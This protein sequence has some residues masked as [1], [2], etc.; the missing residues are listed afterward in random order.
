[1]EAPT[2]HRSLKQKLKSRPFHCLPPPTTIPSALVRPL[3]DYIKDKCMRHLA[4]CVGYRAARSV[5][6]SAGFRYDALSYKLNFDESIP[7]GRS[8]SRD[9]VSR[10]PP[11]PSTPP[12][13]TTTRRS[14]SL[15]IP[16]SN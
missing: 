4:S 7:D 8:P 14:E 9:F 15:G 5:P 2:N 3:E 11:S 16:V 6:C 10:L 12:T 13:P 1:M